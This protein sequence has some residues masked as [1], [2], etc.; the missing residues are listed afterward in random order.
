MLAAYVAK[1]RVKAKE[2]LLIMQAFSPGLFAHGPPPGPHILMRLLRGEITVE[3]V[4]E[5]FARLEREAKQAGAEKNL[6]KM[7]WE[8]AACRIEGKDY[9]KLM[10]DCGVRSEADFLAWLLPKGAWA[11]CT[12]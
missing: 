2:A 1:S 8:C 11:R 10:A 5:E 9:L 12:T 7:H 3:E 6:L 4:D